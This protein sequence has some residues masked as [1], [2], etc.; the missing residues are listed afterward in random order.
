MPQKKTTEELVH[1]ISRLEGQLASVKRELEH[2][3]PDCMRASK[4]LAAAS[5]SFASL[6]RSF[7]ACF[8]GEK[9]VRSVSSKRARDEYATLLNVINS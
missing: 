4:T 8:L 9:Y 3:N 7:V 6:R 1:H 5:R 2:N